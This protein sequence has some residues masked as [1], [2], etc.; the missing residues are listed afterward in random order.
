MQ[1]RNSGA[2]RPKGSK[3][4]DPL[5][6]KAFGAAV[7]AIRLGK[8]ETQEEVGGRAGIERAHWSKI[9]RGKHMPNLAMIIR[10]AAAMECSAAELVAETEKRLALLRSDDA[11]GGRP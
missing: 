1:E 10:I 8:S 5:P 9:E 7:L 4:Y 6:A 3:T 11:D 2:G